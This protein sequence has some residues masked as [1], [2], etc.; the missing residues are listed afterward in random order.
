[1]ERD[2]E[3]TSELKLDQTGYFVTSLPRY[4]VKRNGFTLVELMVVIA[5]ISI[6]S[7]ASVLGFGYL[8]DTLKTREVVGML[9]DLIKQEELKILRG[10]FNKATIHFLKNYVVIEEVEEGYKPELLKLESFC[11]TGKNYEIGYYP[12]ASGVL[13][14]KDGDGKIIDIR[15]VES[16]KEC[17]NFTGSTDNEW[18]Y[19]LNESE[20]FSELLRFIHF[21]IQREDLNNPISITDGSGSKIELS[22]P[23]GKKTIYDGSGAPQTKISLTVTDQNGKSEEI[24]NL[25]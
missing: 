16:G 1:M 2:N 24:L 17:I 18:D 21:N 6:M 20:D 7:V 4:F 15:R 14:Q 22:A 9:G 19:N 8:G 5:I 25:Q 23:Y 12:V 13:T 3:I 11:D 10:D